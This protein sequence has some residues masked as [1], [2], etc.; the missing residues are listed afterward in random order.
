MRLSY[1]LHLLGDFML[2]GLTTRPP[3]QDAAA[4][5]NRVHR[6]LVA[7]HALVRR[8]QRASMGSH[9]WRGDAGL[10]PGAQGLA[11]PC[12]RTGRALRRGAQRAGGPQ[13]HA[14]HLLACDDED[15]VLRGVAQGAA[16]ADGN[17]ASEAGIPHGRGDSP[18]RQSAHHRRRPEGRRVAP[19]RRRR[20]ARKVPMGHVGD[21]AVWPCPEPGVNGS[22]SCSESRQSVARVWGGISVVGIGTAYVSPSTPSD[23]G[24]P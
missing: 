20:D 24:S 16:G 9:L 11:R 19:P 5:A 10:A 7:H 8:R 1:H 6:R 17:R 4:H 13:G 3:A 2:W 15:V 18:R 12:D 14:A 21:V 22:S 23:R